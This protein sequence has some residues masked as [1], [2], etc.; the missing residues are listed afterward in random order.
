MACGWGKCQV[1]ESSA[2]VYGEFA[3][4]IPVVNGLG[5]NVGT[6]VVKESVGAGA[7]REDCIRGIRIGIICRVEIEAD[8][9]AACTDWEVVGVR[10]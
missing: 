9:F 8:E 6:E 3:G 4:E 7:D 2:R 5:S 1:Q 10:R